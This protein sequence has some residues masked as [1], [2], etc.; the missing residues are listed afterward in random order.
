[1]AWFDRASFRRG[2]G[3]LERLTFR[4]SVQQ[5]VAS[6][7]Q[8]GLAPLCSNNVLTPCAGDWCQITYCTAYVMRST[9]RFPAYRAFQLLPIGHRSPQK[10]PTPISRRSR[11]SHAPVAVNISQ[12][13][14]N[15]QCSSYA[16]P[17]E[18]LQRDHYELLFQKNTTLFLGS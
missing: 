16:A 5:A 14:F 7:N 2:V 12:A 6:G 1:M 9:Y 17:E 3:N 18:N 4:M 11:G 15:T 8:C 13:I 10:L